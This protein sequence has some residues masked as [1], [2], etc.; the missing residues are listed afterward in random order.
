M[1]ANFIRMYINGELCTN[2]YESAGSR[3]VSKKA[4]L[5]K[6]AL[7]ERSSHSSLLIYQPYD[8][9]RYFIQWTSLPS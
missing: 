2:A 9:R 5:A 4:M 8:T 6:A 7:Q 1:A 3:F